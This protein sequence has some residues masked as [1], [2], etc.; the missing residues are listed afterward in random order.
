MRHT[1][2]VSE[3]ILLSARTKA[4]MLLSADDMNETQNLDAKFLPKTESVTAYAHR[5]QHLAAMKHS[6]ILLQALMGQVEEN[7]NRNIRASVSPKIT[8]LYKRGEE[9]IDKSEIMDYK[10]NRQIKDLAI[11]LHIPNLQNSLETRKLNDQTD[12]STSAL[13]FHLDGIYLEE[14]EVL[15]ALFDNTDEVAANIAN[16]LETINYSQ[17]E[18]G[19]GE[20]SQLP[21]VDRHKP[22]KGLGKEH[23]KLVGLKLMKK[24]N[25]LVVRAQER[26]LLEQDLRLADEIHVHTMQLDHA[27]NN[28]TE[29]CDQTTPSWRSGFYESSVMAF[30]AE[31]VSE[32]IIRGC[33]AGVFGRETIFK[34]QMD[35]IRSLVFPQNQHSSSR[36]CV[37]VGAR[38]GSG[39]SLIMN[40]AAAILQGITVHVVPTIPLGVDQ[41]SNFNQN[42]SSRRDQGISMRSIHLETEGN[43]N[44]FLVVTNLK[45]LMEMTDTTLLGRIVLVASP[46]TLLNQKLPWFKLLLELSEKRLVRLLSIDEAHKV[47]ED[48]ITYRSE[49]VHLKRLIHQLKSVPV[50]VTSA[51]CNNDYLRRF[52]KITR[53]HISKRVWAAPRDMCRRESIKI[54][55]TCRQQFTRKLTPE[56]KEFAKS[57]QPGEVC[58]VFTNTATSAIKHAKTTRIILDNMFE[59]KQIAL[60]QN[61]WS[62]TGEDAEEEKLFKMNLVTGKIPESEFRCSLFA[63]TSSILGNCGLNSNFFVHGCSQG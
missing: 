40:C 54:E 31:E 8:S 37:F 43:I 59:A 16:A 48:G 51:T 49:F 12:S 53:L 24:E 39:K 14:D 19:E 15:E 36:T 2:I 62:M 11:E 55:F 23:P 60:P 7:G 4:A 52:E 22:H 56:V 17:E 50:V 27:T 44:A 25:I 29:W 47:V 1:V 41:S 34:F 57:R 10:P 21:N 35:G 38:T 33:A 20:A 30:P 28:A 63:L 5:T 61:A 18:A 13:D 3:S 6:G 58:L 9:L 46:P 32:R 26:M 45:K 42:V